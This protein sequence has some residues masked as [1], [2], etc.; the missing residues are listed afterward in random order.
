ML[1]TRRI[2]QEASL[3]VCPGS[4]PSCLTP[5]SPSREDID[6]AA[7]VSKRQ[8]PNRPLRRDTPPTIF[9]GGA[10]GSL[11]PVKP[12]TLFHM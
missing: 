8:T 4:V 7:S 11:N 9:Y 3:L 10:L 6:K 12:H 1:I 2:P 5:V